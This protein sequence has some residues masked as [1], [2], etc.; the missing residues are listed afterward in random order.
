MPSTESA[1]TTSYTQSCQAYVAAREA[2]GT[3][4]TK[5]CK[6]LQKRKAEL[7]GNQLILLQTS[8]RNWELLE[9]SSASPKQKQR[10]HS[11]WVRASALK[12]PRGQTPSG[13]KAFYTEAGGTKCTTFGKILTNS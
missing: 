1:F 8:E 12:D 10:R 5:I 2:R 11:L 4:A 9:Q 6:M 7:V 3:W 13:A